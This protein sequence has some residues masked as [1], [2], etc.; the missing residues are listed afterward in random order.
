MMSQ[1]QSWYRSVPTW[2]KR[3]FAIGIIV[4][5]SFDL[6]FIGGIRSTVSSVNDSAS[7]KKL[8]YKYSRLPGRPKRKLKIALLTYYSN[9]KYGNELRQ[10]TW[11]NKQKYAATHGYDIYDINSDPTLSARVVEEREKMHNFFFYKYLSISETFKG[12]L[13]GKKYDYALW[14]DPD[15]IFLNHS[16]RIEDLIDERFDVIVTTGPPKHPQWGMVVNAG[17]FIVKNS[18]FSARFLDDVLEMSQNH[19]GEFLLENP[20]AAEP[21]NGWLQVCNADGAYWLSDQGILQA[22]FTFKGSDY[23]CHFKKTWMRAFNSEFPWYGEGDLA[24]HFPGRGLED[25]KRLIKAF[26]HHVNLQNGKLKKGHDE[27]LKGD[28]SLTGDLIQLEET[29]DKYNL[30]CNA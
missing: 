6:L 15:A 14:T 4:I 11:S 10:L 28:K 22:L 5:L 17:S 7:S 23:K 2:L 1:V 3:T 27:V 21:I 20:G 19:C 29:F 13:G 25:K 12:S 30:L 16:K 18:D 26:E 9:D 8:N 24:V